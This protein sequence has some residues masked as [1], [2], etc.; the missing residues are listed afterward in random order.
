M[1]EKKYTS[2]LQ[3]AGGAMEERVDYEMSKILENIMDP[4]TEATGKR[5]LNLTI[6]FVPDKN[7]QMVLVKTIAKSTLC[8][9]NPV[10]TALFVQ[11]DLEG[12]MAVEM[13]SNIPGQI[14]MMGE[15]QAPAPIL[16]IVKN[17]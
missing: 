12:V 6:E 4:N 3:M 11:E 5:K 13:T 16:K 9:T 17:A 2:I 15:E 7:R 14:D 10:Q 8:P 1:N